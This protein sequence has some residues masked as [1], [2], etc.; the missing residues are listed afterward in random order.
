MDRHSRLR[1]DGHTQTMT[2]G[3]AILNDM[4]PDPVMDRL[5]ASFERRRA[6][7]MKSHEGKW[8]LLIDRRLG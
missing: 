2:P 3:G 7:M 4:A 6:K 1:R 5:E 8:A